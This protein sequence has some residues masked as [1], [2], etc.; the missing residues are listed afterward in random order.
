MYPVPTPPNPVHLP[1]N[2]WAQF[3]AN[4]TQGLAV[5]MQPMASALA[6]TAGGVSTAYDKGGRFYDKY[7]LP[8][9]Q[10]FTHVHNIGGIQQIWALFQSTKHADTHRNNIKWKMT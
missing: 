2:M 7:Q 6:A 10:G 3:A 4:L 9:V 5:A 1:P 8:V